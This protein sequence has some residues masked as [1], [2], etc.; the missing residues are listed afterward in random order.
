MLDGRQGETAIKGTLASP[1]ALDLKAQTMGLGRI[2]AA[3]VLPNPKGGTLALDAE[4]RAQFRLDG[5]GFDARL[6][7][8][9]DDSRFEAQLGVSGLAPAVVAFDVDIDRIDVDRYRST[10]DAGAPAPGGATRAPQDLAWLRELQARG[11]L[12]VGTLQVAGME[13]SELRADLRA[14][15]GRL[16]LNPLDA[17]L[18]QGRAAGSASLV[19]STPPQ[20]SLKQTLSDISV[21]PL[22]QDATGRAAV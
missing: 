21:G 16:E 19:A 9:L 14:G 11:R 18:Y 6:A 17:R 8:R 1:W 20:L 4:G 3:L 7:G 22:L 10:A 12:G 5:P 15:G 13:A 2:A